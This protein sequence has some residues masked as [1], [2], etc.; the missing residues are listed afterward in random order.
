MEFIMR[1][2]NPNAHDVKMYEDITHTQK[3]KKMMEEGRKCSYQEYEEGEG[4]KCEKRNEHRK[5]RRHGRQ[6]F[7]LYLNPR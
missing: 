6:M 5:R 2:L 3:K 1:I 4:I 7:S